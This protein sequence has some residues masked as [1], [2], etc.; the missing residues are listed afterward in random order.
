MENGTHF[1]KIYGIPES[2]VSN[3]MIENA[4]VNTQD[5]IIAHDSRNVTIRN[6]QI[7]SEDSLIHIIDSRNLNFEN[8]E[9]NIPG[10]KLHMTISGAES[11]SILF[12]NTVPEH[13]VGWNSRKWKKNSEK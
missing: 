3:L 2:P 11:D 8:V 12:E 7:Q 5:L 9:F 10:D 1:L 6:A 4:I 13:P